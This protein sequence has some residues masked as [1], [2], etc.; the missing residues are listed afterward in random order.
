MKRLLLPL[1]FLIITSPQ[2]PGV[3]GQKFPD[4]D[5]ADAKFFEVAEKTTTFPTTSSPYA[6][7]RDGDT[8][9]AALRLVNSTQTLHPR[10]RYGFIKEGL[11]VVNAT[12]SMQLAQSTTPVKPILD[13]PLQSSHQPSHLQRNMANHATQRGKATWNSTNDVAL[14]ILARHKSERDR[15]RA[16]YQ[17]VTTQ[18]RY[19][20]DSSFLLNAGG[21]ERDKIDIAFKR[22][23]GVCENF[24]AIFADIC[25]HANLEVHVIHGYTRTGGRVQPQGHTWCAG[26]VDGEW[27]FFDPTWDAGGGHQFYMCAPGEFIET[28]IPFD[29]IWQLLEYPVSN[30]DFARGIFNRSWAR[31]PLNYRDSIAA[32]LNENRQTKLEATEKRMAAAGLEVSQIR[33]NYAVVRMKLEMERQEDQVN[34][35]D[36][37]VQLVN[38]ATVALN[39]FIELRNAGMPFAAADPS[40]HLQMAEKELTYAETF[41]EKIDRSPAT[42][43]LGTWF[44]RDKIETLRTRIAEQQAFLTNIN[45]KKQSPTHRAPVTKHW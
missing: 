36:S 35:Y 28:H 11:D 4:K 5:I 25:R 19:D 22:R 3:F 15:Y 20:K 9:P 38:N 32:Y 8:T 16:A 29:P 17:W 21:S 12:G 43:V 39:R 2:W 7:T 41:L 1:L 45:A 18:I 31:K 44:A 6:N 40:S 23:R 42:L 10:H 13:T 14:W 37:A 30:A 34:W 24:A 26:M 33:T 27:Y